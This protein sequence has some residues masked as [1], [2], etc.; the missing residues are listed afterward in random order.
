MKK[1]L[2]ILTLAAGIF[3]QP[4][5]PREMTAADDFLVLGVV[6]KIIHNART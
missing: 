2:F 1:L 4:P 3:G 5:Q 6:T